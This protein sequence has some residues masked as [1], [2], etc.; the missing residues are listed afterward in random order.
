MAGGRS[1]CF[2]GHGFFGFGGGLG[3]GAGAVLGEDG[4]QVWIFGYEM[5][6]SMVVRR[7]SVLHVWDAYQCKIYILA[8]RR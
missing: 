1:G 3:S 7:V 2:F 4:F 5:M 6:W 8:G